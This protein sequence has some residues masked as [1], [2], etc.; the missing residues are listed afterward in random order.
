VSLPVPLSYVP[1]QTGGTANGSLVEGKK[2]RLTTGQ[3]VRHNRDALPIHEWFK[4]LAKSSAVPSA[5]QSLAKS[6]AVPSAGQS[7]AKP[8]AVPSAG[9]FFKSGQAQRR[10]KCG[11]FVKS[12]QAQ[13]RTKCGTQPTLL[14]A[15][16]ESC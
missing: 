5:G 13:R 12:G 7:L 8:S 9:L 4:S 15:D 10:T 6:S 14:Q 3:R 16:Q 11:M 2:K 1:A